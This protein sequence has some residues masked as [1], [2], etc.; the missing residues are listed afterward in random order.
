NELGLTIEEVDKLTGPVI[1]RPKSA[2]FRTVDVVG[3]DTLVHVANG[4]YENCPNDEAHGLFKLPDFIQ[5]MMD[6]KWLGSKTG[7]GFYKKITGDG[8][9]SEILS[10]DLNTL[11]YRKNKKASFATLELT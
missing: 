2:T 4:I 10:L 7:Q 5:T 8:G 6:N 1:G 9:K 11:E 3:L